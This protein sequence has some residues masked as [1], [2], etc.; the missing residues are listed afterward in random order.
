MSREKRSFSLYGHATS[1]ALEPQFWAVLD[2]A[3]R[4]APSM[5]RFIADRDDERMEAAPD[6][7]LASY[8]RVWALGY[9]QNAG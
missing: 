5:A 7:G 3:A 8:L 1:I 9:V 4:D 6:Q 2:R